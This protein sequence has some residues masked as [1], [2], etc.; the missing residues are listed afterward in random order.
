MTV[1]CTQEDVEQ[2]L[3]RDLTEDEEDYLD[4]MIEEAQLLVVAYLGCAPDAYLTADNVPDAVRVITSRM[5]ARVIQEADTAPEYFGATQIGET[6]GPFSQQVTFQQGSRLGSPWLAKADRETLEPFR[7]S[8]KAFSID[9]APSYKQYTSEQER[10]E[11]L[12][13]D[14][15]WEERILI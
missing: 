5:V 4:G 12:T 14:R 7:C 15:G 10:A 8:G 9:T 11:L 3:R 1:F 13:G 2:R 6:V